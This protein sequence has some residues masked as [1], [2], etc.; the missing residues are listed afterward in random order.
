[1]MPG[2]YTYT[3]GYDAD[4]DPHEKHTLGRE[5]FPTREAF[6][7]YDR[8][9]YTIKK[10]IQAEQVGLPKG[11]ETSLPPET[12]LTLRCPKCGTELLTDAQFCQECGI[13]LPRHTF[14]TYFREARQKEEESKRDE[15]RILLELSATLLRL[16]EKR[17]GGEGLTAKEIGDEL[18]GT[19]LARAL[20]EH[21]QSSRRRVR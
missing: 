5:Q 16:L 8:I 11:L 15:A 2:D 21:C 4:G 14:A 17:H 13:K 9:A 3:M 7:A 10:V 1:M 18:R 20:Y 12:T 6:N 19:C